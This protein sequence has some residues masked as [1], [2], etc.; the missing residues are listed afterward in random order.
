MKKLVYEQIGHFQLRF[1]TSNSDLCQK[2]IKLWKVAAHV[3]FSNFSLCI[4][5]KTKFVY[6]YFFIDV[7]RI[8]EHETG[9]AKTNNTCV[10]C[11]MSNKNRV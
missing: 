10:S 7:P 8:Q 2:N 5:N 11:C 1:T 6:Q 3:V 9:Q 4:V